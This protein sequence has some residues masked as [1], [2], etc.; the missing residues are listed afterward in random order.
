[1]EPVPHIQRLINTLTRSARGNASHDIDPP[2]QA[3]ISNLIE[4]LR[5]RR[6]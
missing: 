6:L 4:V 2:R 3:Q 5:F 1:V